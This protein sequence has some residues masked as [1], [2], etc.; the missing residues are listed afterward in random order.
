MQTWIWPS[1][2]HCHSLSVASVKSRLVLPFWYRL[3]RTKGL[4][5]VV[6]DK[7]PLNGC[8][9]VCV[10]AVFIL[11]FVLVFC[12]RSVHCC[13]TLCLLTQLTGY[14]LNFWEKYCS[15]K[16]V[17]SHFQLH[18]SRRMILQFLGYAEVLHCLYRSNTCVTSEGFFPQSLKSFC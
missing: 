2:C 13:F 4:T 6:L 11:Y 7:G 5:R 9:C 1:W 18:H 3:T 15:T 17:L 10:Y 14:V 16:C 8:V 12:E